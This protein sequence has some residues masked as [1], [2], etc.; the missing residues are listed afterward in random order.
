MIPISPTAANFKSG[1]VAVFE[2]QPVSSF[3]DVMMLFSAKLPK[4]LFTLPV[5]T[6]TCRL[7]KAKKQTEI[8]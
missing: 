4:V 5:T 2:I 3:K 8:L 1:Y 6:V 7:G